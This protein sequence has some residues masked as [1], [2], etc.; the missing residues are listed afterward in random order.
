M[1]GRILILALAVLGCGLAAPLTSLAGPKRAPQAALV[2][3]ADP[4]IDGVEDETHPRGD[5]CDLS[6]LL[7]A[8][9]ASRIYRCMGSVSGW[10][11]ITLSNSAKD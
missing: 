11:P 4:A 6:Q 7:E 2:R 1:S 10:E 3:A 5:E 8:N 9:G